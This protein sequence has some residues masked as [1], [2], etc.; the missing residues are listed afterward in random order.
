MQAHGQ[1]PRNQSRNDWSIAKDWI[2]E[3]ITLPSEVTKNGRTHVMPL[4]VAAKHYAY[5]MWREDFAPYLDP[6]EMIW[7]LHRSAFDI[8]FERSAKLARTQERRLN[9]YFEM[10]I[11]DGH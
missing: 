7:G 4:T 11:P 5:A 3:N 2:T 10:A 8:L 6:D 9:V 1:A